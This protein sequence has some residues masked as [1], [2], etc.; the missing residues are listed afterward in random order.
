MIVRARLATAREKTLKLCSDESCTANP[1]YV[2][3]DVF[4]CKR[5]AAAHA[6]HLALEAGK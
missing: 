2:V 6:L 4:F 5:H 1:S 3:D